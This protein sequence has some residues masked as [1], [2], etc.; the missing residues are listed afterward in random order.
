MTARGK[1]K[2]GRK[3]RA[4]RADKGGGEKGDAQS[5]ERRRGRTE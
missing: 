1:S 2:T 3:V 4:S 5:G